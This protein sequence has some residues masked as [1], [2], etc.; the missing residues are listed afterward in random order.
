MH[1]LGINLVEKSL[2]L[3]FLVA[4][5]QYIQ[6]KLTMPKK[7][8]VSDQKLSSDLKSEM[9]H[10]IQSQMLY[11][12]PILIFVIAYPFPP[13][14]YIFPELPAA[15]VLYW[16]VSNLFMIGQEIFV[17]RKLSNKTPST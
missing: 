6:I 14:S 10:N 16:T 12:L 3:A 15:L 9:M 7:K 13:L 11:M 2:I 5:S 1:F 4:I 17:R 8:S